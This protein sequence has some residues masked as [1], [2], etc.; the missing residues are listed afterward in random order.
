PAEIRPMLVTKSSTLRSLRELV[1]TFLN[2]APAVRA[3]AAGCTCAESRAASA[4]P[5]IQSAA[6]DA[7]ARTNCHRF[8]SLSRLR[9]AGVQVSLCGNGDHRENGKPQRNGE[10]ET[11][12]E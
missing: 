11:S 7:V 2:A 10:T 3:P 9:R 4:N 1:V 5:R 12:G 8:M 6:V